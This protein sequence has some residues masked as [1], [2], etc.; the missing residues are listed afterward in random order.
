MRKVR[1]DI[2][3]NTSNIHFDYINI[4][5]SSEKIQKAAQAVN[6]R[7]KPDKPART[8]LHVEITLIARSRSYTNRL[9]SHAHVQRAVVHVTVYRDRLDTER[10]ARLHDATCYLTTVCY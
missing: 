8:Y 5:N 2:A 3:K 6:K 10:A 4:Y 7:G 9:V 1:I